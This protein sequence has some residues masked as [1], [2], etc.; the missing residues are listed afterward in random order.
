MGQQPQ[1]YD[2]S[3]F[4]DDIEVVAT[5]VKA[6][7]ALGGFNRHPRGKF[8]GVIQEVKLKTL[9]SGQPIWE[10][11]VQT[12]EGMGQ[13]SIW[14][15]KPNEV[16]QAKAQAQAGSPE[17]LQKVQAGI[18][19]TKRLF[20]DLGLAEPE[21]WAKGENSIVGRLGELVGCAC[22]LVVAEDRSDKNKDKN[23]DRVFINAPADAADPS[24]SQELPSVDESP[25]GGGAQLP[26]IDQVPFM[27]RGDDA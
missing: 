2:A 12:D 27:R 9:P 11:S 1:Q 6:E 17:K 16:A 5:E 8:P 3:G 18:A 24:Y 4:D 20:V 13:Y 25:F 26:D 10:I 22:T 21:G 19:R 14:G 15:W 7:D 23:K